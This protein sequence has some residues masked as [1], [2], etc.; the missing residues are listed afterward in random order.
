LYICKQV[1]WYCAGYFTPLTTMLDLMVHNHGVDS[2]SG[3]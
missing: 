1:I 2:P 3:M